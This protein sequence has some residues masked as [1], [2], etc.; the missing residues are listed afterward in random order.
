MSEPLKSG[1][2][3]STELASTSEERRGIGINRWLYALV[4]FCKYQEEEQIKKQNKFMLS[5]I[6]FQELYDEITEILPSLM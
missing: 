6:V 2:M 3:Y 4:A 1:A 5:N